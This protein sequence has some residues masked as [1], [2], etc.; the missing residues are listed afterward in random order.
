MDGSKENGNRS[1]DE[2]ELHTSRLS[3]NAVE[4]TVL[5]VSGWMLNWRTLKSTAL[6]YK[7]VSIPQNQKLARFLSC[8]LD[9]K[10]INNDN[11]PSIR[12]TPE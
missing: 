2:R 7:A 11:Y 8:S 9:H 10:L 3:F 5:G 12:Q 6:V 1:K 4:Y